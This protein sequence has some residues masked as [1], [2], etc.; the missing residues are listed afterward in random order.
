[1]DGVVK[2]GTDIYVIEVL[3]PNRRITLRDIYA[4]RARIE[5][6]KEFWSEQRRTRPEVFGIVVV[7]AKQE[8]L[9][10]SFPATGI[11]ILRYDSI[12]KAFVNESEVR[13]WIRFEQ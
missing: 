3:P 5:V 1:M 11:V 9:E 7:E 10:E 13:Q 12:A 2:K 4:A 6:A 8:L